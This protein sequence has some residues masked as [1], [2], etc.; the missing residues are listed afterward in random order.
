MQKS[1]FLPQKPY[2]PLGSLRQ[3][4]VFP[5]AE[6]DLDRTADSDSAL[7]KLATDVCLPRALPPSPL[8]LHSRTR[9][10]CTP[11]QQAV[12]DAAHAVTGDS[13]YMP[14]SRKR[15]MEKHPPTSRWVAAMYPLGAARAVS[16]L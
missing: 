2:M 1:F 14:G 4:L 10:P 8:S 5:D 11:Y 12:H 13:A 6:A 7:R 16:V 3:Q 9:T 15:S